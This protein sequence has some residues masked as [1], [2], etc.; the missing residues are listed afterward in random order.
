MSFPNNLFQPQ[1]VLRLLVEGDFERG[2]LDLIDSEVKREDCV[3]FLDGMHR[4]GLYFIYVLELDIHESKTLVGTGTL[5]LEKKLTHNTCKLAHIEN[6]FVDAQYRGK[7]LGKLIVQSIIEKA[8]D[9]GCYRLDLTCTK[10]L[11]PYYNRLGFLREQVVLTIMVPENFNKE[12]ATFFDACAPD[13]TTLILFG[14]SPGM[15][16]LIIRCLNVA[17]FG[18][19]F[20]KLIRSEVTFEQFEEY[21]QVEENFQELLKFAVETQNGRKMIGCCTLIIEK[22]LT[23]S[24]CKLGHL[25]N[26]SLLPGYT[27]EVYGRSIVEAMV[28]CAR[29]H[30][31]Y[32][33]DITLAE[34]L[35]AS[36]E[37][38]G[39]NKRQAILSILFPKNFTHN[40][41]SAEWHSALYRGALTV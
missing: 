30:G 34:A 13:G 21:V 12:K 3:Q 15:E 16:P 28:K 32:R 31:C 17:D 6:I 7:G 26:L 18:E 37:Q 24:L 22:K 36:Y 38:L 4:E 2:F 9:E 10:E 8:E 29:E 25:E 33:V 11:V 27:H 1:I 23:H 40:N 35:L 41:V 39:F 20:L 5:L 19:D 14:N